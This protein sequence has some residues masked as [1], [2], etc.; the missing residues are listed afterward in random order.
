MI[1]KTQD[2]QKFSC[3]M[4]ILLKN[5]INKNVNNVS[6]FL[7]SVLD[8]LTIFLDYQLLTSFYPLNKI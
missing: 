5:S 3:S 2:Q 1:P 7:L 4:E 6:S 8:S